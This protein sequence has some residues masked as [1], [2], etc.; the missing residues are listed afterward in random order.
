M[1][2]NQI[3]R[4]NNKSSFD[5]NTG[6]ISGIGLGLNISCKIIQLFNG[7]IYVNS[8]EGLGTLIKIC[9]PLR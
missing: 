7:E 9:L 5:L 2:E 3:N 8:K 6:K 1:S 4:I